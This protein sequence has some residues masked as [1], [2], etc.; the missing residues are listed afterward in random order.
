MCGNGRLFRVQN[1]LWVGTGEY[2]YAKRRACRRGCTCN[3][4]I[5]GG[6]EIEN[7]RSVNICGCETPWGQMWPVRVGW[8]F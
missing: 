6:Q 8:H 5:G 1:K 7:S 3:S 2:K 4:R